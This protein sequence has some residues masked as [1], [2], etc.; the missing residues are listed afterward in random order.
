MASTNA[1]DNGR[2]HTASKAQKSTK[3]S[4]VQDNPKKEPSI[5]AAMTTKASQLPPIRKSLSSTSPRAIRISPA[6]ALDVA[7]SGIAPTH[8]KPHQ[9]PLI[10][11]SRPK[12][13][14]AQS[15]PKTTKATKV[16]SHKTAK[17]LN[18]KQQQTVKK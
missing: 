11:R 7:S 5:T 17:S 18:G 6:K 12:I 2:R 4:S 14:R 16:D 1:S 10:P 13:E 3:N 15:H 8:Q 9:V